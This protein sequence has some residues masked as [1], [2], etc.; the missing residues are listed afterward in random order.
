M[1]SSLRCGRLAQRGLGDWHRTCTYPPPA[2]SG[3][4]DF[5]G[6][7]E[8]VSAE[9]L[10]CEMADSV[11]LTRAKGVVDW[12]TSIAVI[13]IASVFIFRLASGGPARMSP[14]G[15]GEIP[16]PAEPISLAGATM[17]GTATAPS[18]LLQF[19]DFECPYCGTF[20]RDVLLVIH[21]KFIAPGKL[22]L[23]FRHLPLTKIHRHAESAAMASVCAAQQQRFIPFHD[24]LFGLRAKLN[25]AVF[26][27]SAIA[28]GLDVVGF[29]SCLA[30]RSTRAI[31]ESDIEQARSLGVT[32]TPAFFVGHVSPDGRLVVNKTIKGSRSPEE[33]ATMIG[34]AIADAKTAVR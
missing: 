34:D 13:V 5:R 21:S 16:V 27:V 20:A 24:E 17:I 25:S 30:D 32:G 6:G 12:I 15:R 1:L 31:V 14:P 11:G 4:G 7:I 2:G 29:R 28:A 3:T 23:A 19:S 22:V 33:F 8:P 26:E 10:G 18:A 9:G